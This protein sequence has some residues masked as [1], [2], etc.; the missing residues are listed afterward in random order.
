MDHAPEPLADLASVAKWLAVPV[1][2]LRKWRFEGS[3]P[4]SFRIGRH[5]RYRRSDVEH[6][7]NSARTQTSDD[8][9]WRS[10]RS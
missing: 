2:T 1:S 9:G 6:G 10:A 8:R 4:L 7:S 5:V 3:G